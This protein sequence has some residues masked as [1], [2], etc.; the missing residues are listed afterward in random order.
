MTGYAN[1]IQTGSRTDADLVKGDTL[2]DVFKGTVGSNREAPAAGAASN[3]NQA[4]LA[5]LAAAKAAATKATT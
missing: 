3:P 4:A 2:L 1:N 5:K